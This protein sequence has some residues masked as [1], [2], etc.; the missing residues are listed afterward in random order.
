MKLAAGIATLLALLGTIAVWR[1][2]YVDTEWN[3]RPVELP[4]PG[5]R[6]AVSDFFEIA[7]PGKFMVEVM[8]PGP[9][10]DQLRCDLTLTISGPSQ[11]VSKHM[12]ALRHGGSIGSMGVELYSGEYFELKTAGRHNLRLGAGSGPADLERRGALFRVTRYERP[13]EAFLFGQLQR[14]AG[15]GALVLATATWAWISVRW[16]RRAS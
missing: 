16:L 6:L 14:G 12:A 1:A 13:T 11:S 10:T 2:V 3:W 15:F 8:V 5:A 4:V 7:T 9:P